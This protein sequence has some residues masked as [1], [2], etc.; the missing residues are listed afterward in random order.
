MTNVPSFVESLLNRE[1]A[2]MMGEF[3]GEFY[4]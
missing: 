4:S 3:M 1:V 2:A